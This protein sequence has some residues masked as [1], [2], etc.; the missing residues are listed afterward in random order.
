MRESGQNV[1][2]GNR[3]KWVTELIG[4]L[5]DILIAA[6][7]LLVFAYI[8]HGR[9]YLFGKLE[10]DMASAVPVSSVADAPVRDEQPVWLN[11]HD[12]KFLTSGVEQTDSSYRSENISIELSR[13]E[14]NSTGRLVVY[15]VADIYVRSPEYIRTAIPARGYEPVL[16][17]AAKQ[18]AILAINGDFSFGRIRGPIVRDGMF[19][20]DKSFG[21]V[22][23]LYNNGEMKTFAADE[24]AV[25]EEAAKGIWNVWSFGPALL[26]ADGGRK[27]SFDTTVAEENPRTAIGYYEPGH[28]CIV[29]VNGRGTEGSRGYTMS[30]LSAMFE[31]LGCVAAYNLD[32]GRS[33][34]MAWDCGSSLVNSPASGGRPV[35][36]I[37]Y[38]PKE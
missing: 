28:Y 30:Q 25:S 4:V 11:T 36:D 10:A 23:V 27:T 22:L 13:H 8:H 6:V 17:M 21:D 29:I 9:A 3:P 7:I 19:V 14:D 38:I 24:F 37:I 26:D 15:Y 16:T 20:R 34:V 32:G 18:N 1:R 35:C 2:A 33:S 12:E 31:E 5:A